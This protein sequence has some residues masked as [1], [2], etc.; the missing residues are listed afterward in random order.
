MCKQEM[1]TINGRN[2]LTSCYRGTLK[3]L[4]LEICHA[5]LVII[6]TSYTQTELVSAVPVKICRSVFYK[7]N[8]EIFDV[9]CYNFKTSVS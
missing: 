9:S 3:E 4:L 2:E 1:T 7:T 8:N 6:Y 5:H